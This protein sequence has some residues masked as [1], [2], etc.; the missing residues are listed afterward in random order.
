MV[1][2]PVVKPTRAQVVTTI[3]GVGV[4]VL[5]YFFPALVPVL[6]PLGKI[7]WASGWAT[8]GAGA[9]QIVKAPS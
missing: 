4:A 6:A 9:V 1:T 3:V 2:V 5:G 8:A 7:L